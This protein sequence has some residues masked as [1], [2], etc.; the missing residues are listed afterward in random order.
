MPERKKLLMLCPQLGYGGAERSFVRLANFLNRHHAVTVALFARTY[1]DRYHQQ[2]AEALDPPAL[3]LSGAGGSSLGRWIRRW[4][5]LRRLKRQHD[6]AISFLPG[7]NL[8]NALTAGDAPTIVSVR[9]SRRHDTEGSK[10]WRFLW[11]RLL[12]PLAYRRA[13]CI[14]AASCGLAQ[15]VREGL[16]PALRDKVVGIE[17]LIETA[18]LISASTASVEPEFEQ[19]ARFGTIIACGRL[20]PQKGFHHLIPAFAEVRRREPSAR[21]VIIGDGPEL[22]TLLTL[23]EQLDLMTSRD[24]TQIGKSDILF[25]GFRETPARYY[26]LGRVFAF[27]SLYEGL[28][29]A[30]LEAIAAGIPVLAA[31]CPWGTRS[32]L[33][34]KADGLGLLPDESLPLA[35]PYGTLMPRIDSPTAGAV[36][37]D[38]LTAAIQHP[39]SHT[40]IAERT[41]ALRRFDI[42]ETGQAWLNLVDRY[43]RR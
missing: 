28:P 31:D 25:A 3:L 20:H 10:L 40:A 5:S 34:G 9:G 1:D 43:A 35:L 8:L 39:K 23:S 22:Q 26:R 32:I 29:N 19:L 30:L 18:S 11:N 12:D 15:E 14:V 36:W 2:G 27:S 4:R 38:R 42:A 33:S 6:V 7:A 41:A 37:A 17:G 13:H 24:V 16:A 21:L